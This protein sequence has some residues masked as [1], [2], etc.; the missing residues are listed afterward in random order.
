MIYIS[1]ILI[2]RYVNLVSQRIEKA[3]RKESK[4]DITLKYAPFV[5]A[6]FLDFNV[7][8]SS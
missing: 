3:L 6:F 7:T 5:N 8:I 4:K 1:V 2:L